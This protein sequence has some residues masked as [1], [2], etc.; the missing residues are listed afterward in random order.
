MCRC[1][2]KT[3][4]TSLQ[5]LSLL[6]SNRFNTRWTPASYFSMLV[7]HCS[8]LDVYSEPGLNA[9]GSSWYISVL[10]A[11]QFSAEL[12]SLLPD[13][14][15]LL[16]HIY[17]G[18]GHWAH[19]V[20]FLNTKASHCGHILVRQF[21]FIVLWRFILFV[22]LIVF[23]ESTAVNENKTT[24]LGGCEEMQCEKKGGCFCA[25]ASSSSKCKISVIVFEDLIFFFFCAVLYTF[26]SAI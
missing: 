25:V 23:L 3:C 4:P 20:M 17:S 7:Y 24:L 10:L 15:N 16:F 22:I 2:F 12:C 18:I 26:D 19:L 13:T 11:W 6:Q 8:L 5:M 14:I 21:P 1:Y 9:A